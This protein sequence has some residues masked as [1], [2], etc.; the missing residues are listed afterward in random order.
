[1]KRLIFIALLIFSYCGPSKLTV[2]SNDNTEW[3]LVKRQVCKSESQMK[4]VFGPSCQMF[5]GYQAK[6]VV[7]QTLRTEDY[8]EIK[9]EIF[10]TPDE[11][12][13]RNLYQRYQTITKAPVGSDGSSSPGFVSFYRKNHFVR[14]TA[15]RN[16]TGK[17]DYLLDIARLTDKKLMK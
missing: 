7:I 2:R 3:R 13:A 12:N 11:A 17:D 6:K 8:K 14:V 16:L 9:V 10:T 4:K 5:I 15:Q 1:M